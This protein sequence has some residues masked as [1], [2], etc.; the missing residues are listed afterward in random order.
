MDDRQKKYLAD[1]LQSIN[2]IDLHLSGK[3]D[4]HLL[5]D[6][7]TILSA[8]KYEFSVIGEVINLLL[9]L[10]ADIK[11][12]DARKIVGFRNRMVHEYDAIDNT[13]LWSIII[14]YLPKLKIQVEQLLS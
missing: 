11:I 6:N 2:N 1:V 3:R 5:N 10:D 9:K 14:N 7:I 12:D 8:I 13:Q 4:F